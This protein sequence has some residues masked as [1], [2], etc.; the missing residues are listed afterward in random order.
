M[1]QYPLLALFVL[2]LFVLGNTSHTSKVSLQGLSGFRCYGLTNIDTPI[3][4]TNDNKIECFSL[5]GNECVTELNSDQKCREFVSQNINKLIPIQCNSSNKEGWCQEARAFFYRKWHC[6]GETGLSTGIKIDEESGQVSCLSLDGRECAWGEEGD[7]LCEKVQTCSKTLSFVKPRICSSSQGSNSYLSDEGTWCKAGYA[8]FKY[9]GRWMCK[10]QTGLPLA[11]RMS[12]SGEVQCGSRNGRDCLWGLDNDQCLK[13]VFNEGDNFQPLSCGPM[14]RKFYGA[15]G[16]LTNHWCR[17]TWNLIY[18]NR[19]NLNGETGLQ[20]PKR[21]LYRKVE[22]HQ[23]VREHPGFRYIHKKMKKDV[24]N[25]KFW[26]IIR[27]WSR[28]KKIGLR[29][30]WRG[31]KIRGWKYAVKISPWFGK[32]RDFTRKTGINI[33]KHLKH[34]IR[35]IKNH[36]KKIVKLRNNLLK[37]IKG[38][39]T[40]HHRIRVFWNLYKIIANKFRYFPF[41]KLLKEFA[42]IK[43]INLYPF[44]RRVFRHGLHRTISRT[45]WWREFLEFIKSKGRKTGR[46]IGH[47]ISKYK[48]IKGKH[49][50]KF[51]SYVYHTKGGKNKAKRIYIRIKWQKFT[52]KIKTGNFGR[53]LDKFLIKIRPTGGNGGR[54]WRGGRRWRN[55]RGHRPWR[56]GRGFRHWKGGNFWWGIYRYGW[57]ETTR[58]I[59]WWRWFIDWLNRRRINY[60]RHFIRIRRIVRRWKVHIN[61]RWKRLIG[62]FKRYKVRKT[63]ITKT[64]WKNIIGTLKET[65]FIEKLRE[66]KGHHKFNI[67]AFWRGIRRRG[68][69]WT[70]VNMPWWIRFKH[71]GANRGYHITG[72]IRRFKNILH[73]NI[74]KY[75]TGYVWGLAFRKIKK[76]Q[77]YELF[78][79]WAEKNNINCDGFWKKLKRENWNEVVTSKT[80]NRFKK[81]GQ[82]EELPFKKLISPIKRIARRYRWNNRGRR[83]GK[84]LKQ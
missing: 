67:N 19:I 32:F 16:Y 52:K 11:L 9:T 39:Y 81:W 2:S 76:T 70:Y 83:V 40:P 54:P 49:N 27:E 10:S 84:K 79:K 61:K 55:R 46:I 74:R 5:D 71:W 72:I 25:T 28:R 45:N 48:W 4:L 36:K 56:G 37:R 65:H 20:I 38:D 59:R 78:K 13:L 63:K 22:K 77:L 29:D 34:F 30:F 44:W 21:H 66:F 12:D 33:M 47:F 23:D 35:V 73:D 42:G 15:G 69:R 24:I 58:R 75:R 17:N 1:K 57:R 82:E 14:H 31:L 6:S 3:R 41:W 50:H 51:I 8:F 64:Q 80:W 68:W 7:R 62:R 26:R 60:E 18:N 43:K 53:L